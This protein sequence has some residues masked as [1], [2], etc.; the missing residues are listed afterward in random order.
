MSAKINFPAHVSDFFYG[1]TGF[2][3]ERQL[4]EMRASREMLFMTILYGEI[5]GV[6]LIPQYYSLSLL[7]YV[8]PDIA[9]WKRR[10]MREKDVLELEELDLHGL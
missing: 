8:V 10:A 4:V 1:M 2:E 9:A 6:P 5:L 7:P 3:F